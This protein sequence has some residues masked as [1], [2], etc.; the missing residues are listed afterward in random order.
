VA[1]GKL[2]HQVAPVYPAEAKLRGT[3]GMVVLAATIGT[4][5]KILDLDVVHSMGPLLDKASLEAV[6]DWRYRPT[7]IDGTPV[8]VETRVTV[9]FKLNH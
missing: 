5:G 1:A 2:I 8:V 7:T 3:E 9:M 6:R 4:D